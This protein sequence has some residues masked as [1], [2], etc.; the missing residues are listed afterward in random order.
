MTWKNK[1]FITVKN[2]QTAHQ[3]LLCQ[4]K[5]QTIDLP[6]FLSKT[7]NTTLYAINCQLIKNN[8][9]NHIITDITYKLTE[10]KTMTAYVLNLKVCSQG[11]VIPA[12]LSW[13]MAENRR[14]NIKHPEWPD[15]E[16][17]YC[18]DDYQNNIFRTN[19]KVANMPAPFI[20]KKTKTI[21]DIV[22]DH[23]HMSRSEVFKMID[24]LQGIDHTNALNLDLFAAD[25]T[26]YK[27]KD[28]TIY[29]YIYAP[30]APVTDIP[31]EPSAV[32]HANDVKSIMLGAFLQTTTAKTLQNIFGTD[33][34][35]DILEQFPS[36]NQITRKIQEYQQEQKQKEFE[37]GD[38]VEIDERKDQPTQGIVIHATKNFINC[39]KPGCKGTCTI[40]KS[41]T[42]HTGTRINL[43][44]AIQ[45][46]A[47]PKIVPSLETKD[48][49][50]IPKTYY[51][52]PHCGKMV[53]K[54]SLCQVINNVYK[55]QSC[56]ELFKP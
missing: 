23:R 31:D 25:F 7:M 30:Y 36:T 18:H 41:K 15:M 48:Y 17:S 47:E 32:S 1:D 8:G 19:H 45:K 4:F 55:C 35:A 26:P 49:Q 13:M 27:I 24:A 40:E 21:T 29:R 5:N 42:K 44:K 22:N 9:C 43:E 20:V 46:M 52:C 16:I 33:D 11:T 2:I 38:I 56:R 39:V 3:D 12:F 14:R 53:Q 28:H 10:N 50:E 51:K 54:E 34:L 6:E 37:Y